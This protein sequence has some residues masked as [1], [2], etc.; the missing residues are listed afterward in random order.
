MI[1]LLQKHRWMDGWIDRS[2]RRSLVAK[3]IDRSLGRSVCR[4]GAVDRR[5]LIRSI[6]REAVDPRS[7]IGSIDQE[8]V[9][10]RSL[11]RSIDREAIDP[12]SLIR[13]IGSCRSEKLINR[14]SAINRLIDRSEVVD[15]RSL[16]IDRSIGSCSSEKLV[17][18]RSAIDRSIGSCRSE[19]IDQSIDGKL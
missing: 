19:K 11:I 14:A 15:P 10:P 18:W 9:D 8:A 4:L 7:L 12:R 1:R 16:S 13:S 2:N 5:S 3:P 17:I 6:D